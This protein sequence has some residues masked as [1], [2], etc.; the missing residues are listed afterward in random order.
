MA[1]KCCASLYYLLVGKRKVKRRKETSGGEAE[2]M[3]QNP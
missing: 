1:M 2:R 3:E